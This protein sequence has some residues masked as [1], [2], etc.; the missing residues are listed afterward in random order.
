[1][2]NSIITSKNIGYLLFDIN[3]KLKKNKYDILYQY[4]KNWSFPTNK[5]KHLISG[6]HFSR[7][8]IMNVLLNKFHDQSIWYY[9][10]LICNLMMFTKHDEIIQSHP[11]LDEINTLHDQLLKYI[12]SLII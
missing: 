7:D 5:I 9:L 6:Q 4:V 10:Y 1:M 11:T 2:F 8:R 12:D 3:E